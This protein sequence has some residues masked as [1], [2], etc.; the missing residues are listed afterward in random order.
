MTIVACLSLATNLYVFHRLGAIRGEGVHL[1]AAW[2][3]TR[4]D[5]VANLCVILAGLAVRFTGFGYLD[6]IVGA[7]TRYTFFSRHARFSLRPAAIQILL[8]NLYNNFT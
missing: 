5:V 3:F 2:I 1:R 4:A 7:G 8:G 6:P